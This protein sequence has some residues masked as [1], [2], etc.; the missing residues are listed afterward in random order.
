MATI[1]RA[2]VFEPD[3]AARGTGRHD[4]GCYQQAVAFTTYHGDGHLPAAW[5]GFYAE[6]A[7]DDDDGALFSVYQ[8]PEQPNS[9]AH[10]RYG[11]LSNAVE[12]KANTYSPRFDQLPVAGNAQLQL[13]VGPE[14]VAAGSDAAT[15]VW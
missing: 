9:G 2:T 4:V 13:P 15:H 1:S 14:H 10:E 12:H 11:P 7:D 8:R 5:N 3:P 6:S